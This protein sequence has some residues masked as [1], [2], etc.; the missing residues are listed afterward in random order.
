MLRENGADMPDSLVETLWAIIQK[1]APGGRPGSGG[2]GGAKL[3]PREDAGPY[4]GLALP[5]TRDRVK[6]MEEEMLAEARAKAEQSAAAE[7]QRSHEQASTRDGR[8]GRDGRDGRD[9]DGRRR[10]RSRSRSRERRRDRSRSRDRY[11]GDRYGGGGRRGRSSS[12]R[13][14]G[15]APPPLPDE[16]EMYGVYRVRCVVLAF[17]AGLVAVPAGALLGC[18][19]HSMAVYKCCW[20]VLLGAWASRMW[21]LKASPGCPVLGV[22]WVLPRPAPAACFALFATCS[23]LLLCCRVA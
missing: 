20:A 10:S 23:S 4:A 14:R 1:M 11:G 5:D 12:P 2:G 6:E 7:R 17:A 13:G 8:S 22:H 21:Q 16:P 18:S 3:Q 15:G 9:R 19:R